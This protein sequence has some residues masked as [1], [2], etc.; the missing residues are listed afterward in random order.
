MFVRRWFWFLFILAAVLVW[1][2]V[3]LVGDLGSS[4]QCSQVLA[5]RSQS[6]LYLCQHDLLI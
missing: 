2:V 6:Q 4:W 3:D 5:L 1:A